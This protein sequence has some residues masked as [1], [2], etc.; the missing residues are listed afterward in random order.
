M[1]ENKDELITYQDGSHEPAI[2]A[3]EVH[4]DEIPGM[5]SFASE[6]WREAAGKALKEFCDEVD[7]LPFADLSLIHISEPTRLGMISYAVFCLKKKKKRQ[8]TISYAVLCLKRTTEHV[9]KSNRE[10]MNAKNTQ[11]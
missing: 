11:H 3:S 10:E 4:R 7:S 9:N 8:T 5:Y 2:L 6:K 1:E